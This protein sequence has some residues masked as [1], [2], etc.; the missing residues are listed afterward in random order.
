MNIIKAFINFPLKTSYILQKKRL[1]WIIM[2]VCALC[3]NI[4]AH[5]VFQLYMGLNACEL[6]DYIRFAM[7]CIFFAS[8]IT[9][10]SP[11]NIILRILF[12]YILNGYGIFQGFIWNIKLEKN[13]IFMQKLSENMDFFQA[14]GK[15]AGCSLTPHYPLGL[16]L[17]SWFPSWFSP[18]GI[19][20]QTNWGFLGFNMPECLFIFYAIYISAFI[21]MI[22]S[23]I[24]YKI[25]S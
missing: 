23:F 14:G 18:Q 16:P 6:C 11:S 2:G 19:C 1:S 10:I 5:Y 13:H 4:I 12:G 8:I 24:K 25:L 7:F 9:A 21:I 17:D 3:L 20:G 15:D 22:L